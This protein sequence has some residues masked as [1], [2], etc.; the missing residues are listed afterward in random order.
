MQ[1]RTLVPTMMRLSVRAKSLLEKASFEQRKSQA[2]IID[3]LIIEHLY[4]YA[5]TN[6][7]LNQFLRREP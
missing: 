3:T 2:A 7:R 6:D 4:R 1:K 5:S